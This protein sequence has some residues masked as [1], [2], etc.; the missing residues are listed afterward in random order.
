MGAFSKGA[1]SRGLKIIL[2]VCQV[3]VETSLRTISSLLHLQVVGYV[4]RTGKVLLINR[5]FCFPS[6]IKH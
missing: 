1:N 3:P 2:V 5:C 6:T 4:L